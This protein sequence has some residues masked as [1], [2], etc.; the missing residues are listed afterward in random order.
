[1]HHRI[2]RGLLLSVLSLASLA[3]AQPAEQGGAATA[4]LVVTKEAGRLLFAQ[5]GV[6]VGE[7]LFADAKM[8]RPAFANLRAPG[9]IQVTRNFPPVEGKDATDHADMHPGLWLGF[10]DINGQDFWR[11]GGAMRHEEFTVAPEWRD[12]VLKFA[13]RST[14][15]SK[16]GA[17]MGRMDSTFTLKPEGNALALTWEAIFHATEGELVFG[18]QEEMGFGVR[19]ATGITEQNGG[20]IT[21]SEGLTSAKKTW[22]QAAR[23]C[24]YSGVINGQKVGITI[25]P[26]AANPEPCWWHNRDYGVFVANAFG[27]KAMKQGEK[28]SVEVKQG[29]T[30]RLGFTALLHA[31]DHV[32]PGK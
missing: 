3:A 9:G 29:G 30:L 23:W 4:P 1:M 16:E 20:V 22:G 6:P 2:P 15:L 7:F 5:G 27:R 28:Q 32:L 25:T 13:T 19:V 31:G 12:G 26:D 14:L 24:D 17:R 21:N 18:D 8:K 11:N 10:G